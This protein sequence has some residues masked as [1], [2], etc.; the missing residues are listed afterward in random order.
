MKNKEINNIIKE[1]ENEGTFNYKET[2]INNIEEEKDI[3]ELK[4]NGAIKN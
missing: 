4:G 2:K 1:N 3:I